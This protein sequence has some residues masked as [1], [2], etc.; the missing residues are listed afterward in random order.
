[1]LKQL[2]AVILLTVTAVHAWAQPLADR[3]PADAVVY[4]GWRGA[5]DP[6]LG[7]AGS[8][9]QALIDTTDLSGVFAQTLEVI[10]RANGGDPMAGLVVDLVRSIGTASWT[11]PTAA[12]LQTTPDPNMPVRLTV[13][14]RA[15]GEKGDEL[16]ASL[17]DLVGQAPPNAPLSIGQAQ[18]LVSLTIGTPAPAPGTADAPADNA[19]PAATL[20]QVP[21]FAQALAKVDTDGVLIVYADAQG[22]LALIDRMVEMESGP[23]EQEMWTKVRSALGLEGLNAVAWSGEFDGADW[24][25]DMFIDAP[26]PRIGLLSL[27][28]GEPITDDDLAVVPIEATWLAAARLDLGGLLDKAREAMTQIDPEMVEAFNQGL[29]Q[30]NQI[31]GIDIEADLLRALGS[32]WV[33]YTDPGA[34]GSGMMGMCLVNPLKDAEAAERSLISLQALANAMM[35]QIGANAGG[36]GM[37]IRF[38]TRDDNGMTLNTLGIPFIAPTWSVHD[39]KLYVG[40]FP[41]TVMMAG[42][43]ARAGGPTILDSE[44]FQAVMTRLD[45]G[46]AGASSSVYTD[47]PRTAGDAEQDMVMLTQIGSGLLAMFG[48]DSV[49]ILLPPFARIQPL[50]KSTGQVAWS[51]DAG[52]HS[53]SISPFPGSVMLGPQGSMN[54]M[55]TAPM[56]VGIML[57]ALGA[58]RRSAQQVHSMS[59]ARQLLMSMFVYSADNNDMFPQDI[60]IPLAMG[61]IDDPNVYISKTSG[62]VVPPMFNQWS[63]TE[64]A[65][66]IRQNA[67][68]ILIPM[69]RLSELENPSETICLF[70]LPWDASDPEKLAIGFA[71]GHAQVMPVWEAE[72]LIQAQTGKT[73]E[74]LIERQQN[75]QPAVEKPQTPAAP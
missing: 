42:D 66:W 4:V 37:R 34:T 35:G 5:D 57:P 44:R 14:W 36:V 48:G 51:D 71:D 63:E 72:E 6:D 64:Q 21:G 32:A 69:P 73:L 68:Y 28:D 70:E 2:L 54:S 7:Y 50:L 29:L 67:S 38:H 40:L 19:A 15:E 8:N 58:A 10:Q 11:Q 59:N 3:V 74:E 52:Y 25:C 43:R 61:Y 23:H 33:M 41:Q 20:A 53:R 45:A 22:L 16:M 12:Y 47:L 62:K 55:S 17:Q 49:P 9:L 60:A 27:L 30:G 65:Q 31:T 13:L 75:Y 46:G 56:M 26:A 18:G 1:M 39:G 24:R